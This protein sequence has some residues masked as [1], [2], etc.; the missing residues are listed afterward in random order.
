MVSSESKGQGKRRKRTGWGF[1]KNG[2][3]FVSGGWA[4]VDAGPRSG[5]TD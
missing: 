1:W 4:L 3:C 2:T 5:Q